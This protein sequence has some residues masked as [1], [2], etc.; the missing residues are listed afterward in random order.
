MADFRRELASEL[1]AAGI[2]SAAVDAVWPAWWSSDAE[3]NLSARAEVRLT[4]ARRLGLKPSSLLA[5]ETEFIWRDDA[6]FKGLGVASEDQQSA[7]TSFGV[8]LA[9]ALASLLP[10]QIDVSDASAV[11]Q[12]LTGFGTVGLGAVLSYCWAVNVPVV[13]LKAFPLGQKRMSAMSAHSAQGR[14]ILLGRRSNY[15]SQAAFLIAHELGHIALG[16]VDHGSGLVDAVAPWSR[17]GDDPEET[18]ADRYALELLLGDAD[19]EFQPSVG[20]FSGAQL[21]QVAVKE[22]PKRQIDPGV[23]ALSVGYQTGRWPQ[24]MRAMRIIYGQERSVS[25]QIN[26]V[27]VAELNRYDP[28]QDTIEYLGSVLD[29]G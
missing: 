18:L 13:Q 11:R 27:A 14:A 3:D 1:S 7:L 19:T 2:A 12:A 10:P 8:A 21:A 16:H 20:S 23:L 17:S 29:F 15:S 9:G 4:V 5:G 26:R 25:Q 6:R 24:A 28:S 22:G